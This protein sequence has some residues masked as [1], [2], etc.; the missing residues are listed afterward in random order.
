LP[1]P[2]S[3]AKEEST[4]KHPTK[5]PLNMNDAVRAVAA[6]F[7]E[8]REVASSLGST[9]PSALFNQETKVGIDS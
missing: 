3:T 9:S 7:S 2:T 4:I 5:K 1:S 8:Q 6:A